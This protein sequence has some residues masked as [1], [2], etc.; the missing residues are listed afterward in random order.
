MKN[1]TLYEGDNLEVLRKMDRKSVDLIYLDPPFNS[2]KDYGE[3]DDRWNFDEYLSFMETRVYEL[4]RILK[5][6]GSIYLHCDSSASHYLK[7]MMDDVFGIKNFRNEIIWFYRRWATSSKHFQK[8]HDVILYY[9]KSNDYVFNIQ[10]IDVKPSKATNGYTRNSYVKNGKTH[11][12][13]IVRDKKQF[14]QA[15][16]KNKIDFSGN[17]RIIYKKDDVVPAIDVFEIQ[18]LNSSA[19]ERTG[20]PTQKPE[21]LL[22]RIIKASS[23]ENDVILDPFYGSGTSLVVA[24]KL[25]RQWIGIDLNDNYEL[26]KKRFKENFGLMC[27]KIHYINNIST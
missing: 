26:I 6:T 11:K 2:N 17:P 7:I 18:F 21:A 16:E 19:K 9:T 8:M 24:E 13:I 10:Y 22:E 3:F 5:D 12:Q 1:R 25:K 4:H 20:Y 23:N 14:Q 27:P 15:V